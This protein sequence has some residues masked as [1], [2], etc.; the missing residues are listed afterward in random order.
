MIRILLILLFI[1]IGCPKKNK[2]ESNMYISPIPEFS[3]EDLDLDDL[4]EDT[5]LGDG[6]DEE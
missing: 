1:L 3:D 2:D 5:G 4:P 6:E